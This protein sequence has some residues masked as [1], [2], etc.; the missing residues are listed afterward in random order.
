[1]LALESTSHRTL[2]LMGDLID[3]ASI[4]TC[5]L[6]VVS[7]S[8]DDMYLRPHNP[9]IGE[10][11]CCLGERCICVWMA[12]WRY[13]EETDLAFI[14]TE[15][16]LPSQHKA[17]LSDGALPL[18][19]GKCLVCVRYFQVRPNSNQHFLSLDAFHPAAPAE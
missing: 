15:F 4:P 10:R 8:H 7:K 2:Q 12:R 14:G 19:P 16:L 6:E 18:S 3:Q 17:F 9:T 5:E 13:G 11:P 1:M